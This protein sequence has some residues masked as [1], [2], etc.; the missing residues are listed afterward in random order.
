MLIRKNPF[1]C[2]VL[3]LLLAIGSPAAVMADTEA[4]LRSQQA[5]DSASYNNTISQ[6]E[7]NQAAHNALETEIS[8]LDARLISMMSQISILSRDIADTEQNIAEAESALVEAEAVRDSQYSNMKT[9]IQYIYERNEHLSWFSFL[10]A[11]KDFI[12]FLNRIQYAQQINN[13]DRKLL[14]EYEQ[15]VTEINALKNTLTASQGELMEEKGNL[16]EQQNALDATLTE[17]RQL[18]DNYDAELSSLQKRAEEL[19]EKIA[20]EKAA[21]QEIEIEKA[22]KAEEEARKKAEEEARKKAEEEARK[23]AEEEAQRRAAES[24]AAAAEEAAAAQRAAE[25]AA[26]AQRAA[27]AAAASQAAAQSA[28]NAK[29]WSRDEAFA[30]Y[31]VAP[32]LQGQINLA[33][34]ICRDARANNTDPNIGQKIVEYACQFLGNPYVLG[35]ESL[36]NGCDCAGFAK[37]VYAHFGVYFPRNGLVIET[38]GVPVGSL[39]EARPG[40]IIMYYGHTALYM[41]NDS[42][43]NASCPE[44]GICT[45]S[46]ATY[47]SIYCIRRIFY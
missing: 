44:L 33:A 41:G 6:I 42:I 22:R 25:E 26:A 10:A 38:L 46:P 28:S 13:Y 45:R 16:E 32:G 34:Q 2:L 5:A 31:A 47:R 15:C 30:A 4:E 20:L 12:D 36:T 40:D 7:D 37:E 9:R 11:S 29:V 3:C 39:A 35:G 18:S 1:L 17:K 43:V 8:D 27:E 14:T 23:K 24:A 21:L 19:T